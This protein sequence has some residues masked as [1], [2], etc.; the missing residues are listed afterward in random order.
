MKSAGRERRRRSLALVVSIVLVVAGCR[1]A[2]PSSDDDPT[3]SV[4]PSEVPAPTTSAAAATTTT[5][6]LI[7]LDQDPPVVDLAYA[8]RVLDELSRLDGESSRI[9][10]R[11]KRLTPEAEAIMTAIFF[12]SMLDDARKALNTELSIDL[13]TW[14]DPPGDPV[15]KALRVA[16]STPG[17]IAIRADSDLRPRYK[18]YA[19]VQQGIGLILQ[20]NIEPS[21]TERQINPT[22]WLETV[23]STTFTDA[24]LAGACR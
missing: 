21:A 1:G 4:P 13:R 8:Q 2:A 12:G 18:E 23:G 7:P 14:R 10:Y 6:P 20:R 3:I 22:L 11:E 15:V 16:S 24:E 19:E 17:C 9:I 5:A